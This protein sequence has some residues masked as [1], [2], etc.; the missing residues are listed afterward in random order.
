MLSA[1]ISPH[2]KDIPYVNLHE[3]IRDACNTIES[4]HSRYPESYVV[5]PATPYWMLFE[6][7]RLLYNHEAL[8]CNEV[9]R[10]HSAEVDSG[11]RSPVISE[12][13]PHLFVEQQQHNNCYTDI[14]GE[15]PQIFV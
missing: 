15:M 2:F 1:G 4:L 11:R 14:D 9:T 13:Y 8:Y 10:D 3:E 7:W 5:I 12:C 6:L